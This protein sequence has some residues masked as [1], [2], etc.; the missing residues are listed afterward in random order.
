MAAPALPTAD[1]FWDPWF[2]WFALRPRLTLFLLVLAALGPFITKPFNADDPLF[3]WAARHIQSHPANP[4]GF[5]AN[6]Y[7][8]SS[9]MWEVTKNPPLA[10]YYLAVAATVLG[11]SE[12]A[13]HG[14]LLLPALAAI[15]GTYRLARRFSSQPAL[16]AGATLFTPVFLVSSSTL[17]CDTLMLAFWVWAAVLWVEG[18]EK[19]HVRSGAQR[20][21]EPEKATLTSTPSHRTVEGDLRSG[22]GWLAGGGGPWVL[23]A[24]AALM[25]LA[26]LTKYFGACLIPL[27]AAYSFMDRRRIGSWAFFFL[28]PI[29]ALAGYE[30]ATHALYGKGLLAEAADYAS[31]TRVLTAAGVANALTAL[32]FTGGCLAVATFLSPLLWRPQ[33]L[34]ALAISV[35]VMG[36]FVFTNSAILKSYEELAGT[37]RGFLEVQ[38][39]FWA[40]GGASVVA[41]AVADAW[42]RRDAASWLLAFWVLGTFV[43]SGFFNWI[44]NARS[45]L[46]MAPAVG[47]LLARRLELGGGALAHLR[48]GRPHGIAMFPKKPSSVCLAAGAILALLVARADFLLAGAVRN[49]AESVYAKYGR[50]G[51]TL[52]FEGHWGFQ[53]YIEQLGQNAK[54]VV[55]G[56]SRPALGDFLAIPPN[57]S[58][59]NAPDPNYWH[60]LEAMLFGGP[61]WLTTTSR[62]IGAGFHASVYGPLPFA[63]GR[64]PSETVFTYHLGAAPP[65]APRKG[66]PR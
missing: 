43:F 39:V 19:L 28:V 46:P 51:G 30:W 27:L 48:A 65:A 4:Y 56:S 44:V 33:A 45:I 34:V 6:W 10:C 18:M 20:D 59:I 5:D 60:P 42:S 62:E 54:P 32:A 63:F 8:S 50:G 14:A 11:W 16:A 7:G 15:L 37:S 41:L 23:G 12:P 53:F 47:I 57:N 52:W 21:H 22:E 1:R 55:A 17:M 24:S 64:V 2:R 49:S 9:P 58:N 40:I 36:V 25:A 29:A 38:I 31:A 66:P 13:L 35:T 61:R 26:A 3:V